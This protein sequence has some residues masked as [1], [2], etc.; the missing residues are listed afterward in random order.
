MSIIQIT[1]IDKFYDLTKGKRIMRE[2]VIAEQLIR[3]FIR[4]NL[5]SVMERV[6]EQKN[7]HVCKVKS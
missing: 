4:K 1:D 6:N 3:K 2:E 7:K 5:P